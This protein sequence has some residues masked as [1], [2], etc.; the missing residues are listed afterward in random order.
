MVC[1]EERQLWFLEVYSVPGFVLNFV[2]QSLLWEGSGLPIAETREL[3][4]ETQYFVYS[5]TEKKPQRQFNPVLVYGYC[6]KEKF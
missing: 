6:S 5:H 2:S 3:R 4:S 1:N